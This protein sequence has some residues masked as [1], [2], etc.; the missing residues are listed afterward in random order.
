MHRDGET[1]ARGH[2]TDAVDAVDERAPLV[3]GELLP[4]A[5][6]RP[7]G[8]RGKDEDLGATVGEPARLTLDRS[9]LARANGWVV[10]HGG[11]ESADEAQSVRRE[12]ATRLA[13]IGRQESR[14]SGLG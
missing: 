11:D 13:G 6:A 12:E 14:R 5:V 3:F 10:Q 8:G 2:L 9:E 1:A 7:P 4:C